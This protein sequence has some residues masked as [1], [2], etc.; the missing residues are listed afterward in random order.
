MATEPVPSSAPSMA[1]TPGTSTKFARVTGSP[2]AGGR[3]YLPPVTDVAMMLERGRAAYGRREWGSAFAALHEA[4]SAAALALP[5]LELLVSSAGLVGRGDEYVKGME[6]LYQIHADAGRCERAAI[7]AF[8][9]AFRLI[10]TGE[11]GRA[12]GWIVR[13]ERLAE[14]VGPESVVHG[15]LLFPACRRHLGAGE[16]EA[17]HAAATQAV[18][19]AERFQDADLCALARSLLGRVLLAQGHIE[20]GLSLLDECMLAAGGAEVSPHLPGL[21]YCIAIANCHRVYALDRAR[22]WTSALSTW[23]ES[24]PELV[25]FATSCLVHRAEILQLSGAWHEAIEEARRAA[26][27][28]LP[29]MAPVEAADALYQQA[30]IQRLRGEFAAAEELYRDASQR[31]REPQPGL[32]LLRLAQGKTEAAAT[33]IRRVLGSTKDRLDRARLL[34]AFI[35]ILLAHGGVDEARKGSDE[36]Q[37]IAAQYD[38]E[39]LGAMAAHARGAVMFAEGDA[40]GAL[41]PLR[42]AFQVWQNV[43]APYIAARIRME[44]ARVCRVLCDEDG[45]RLELDAAREVFER[46]GAAA[47]L[48]A[49]EKIAPVASARATPK[50]KSAAHGLTA[51][52]IEVLRLVAAGKTN[53]VI[54]KELFLSEKTVDRH[55]SNIFAKVNVASRAAATA[56][57]YENGLV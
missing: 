27:C 13:C 52:E 40:Q 42:Q 25:A 39:V 16:Y 55:I 10:G 50:G 51:R 15:Y 28:V 31:G 6:R 38:T 54:A 5:D 57:A 35:E 56:Y 43:G 41:A 18:A 24:Q 26:E 22:E 32:S 36:L 44:L 17:A 46:L 11:A 20:R 53:K 21:I 30:E 7:I 34:P 3:C 48:A 4:D 9:L 33:A 29:T 23:C 14:R 47:D 37:D 49:V 12:S 19:I 2:M 1:E 45:A 8:W